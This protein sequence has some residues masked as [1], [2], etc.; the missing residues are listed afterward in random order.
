MEYYLLKS[1]RPYQIPEKNQ[2]L[3]CSDYL[4]LKEEGN[5]S[6]SEY[7]GKRRN[8]E[9]DGETST[10]LLINYKQKIKSIN[11]GAEQMAQWL[12][13]LFRGAVFGFQ[14]AWGCLQTSVTSVLGY[15]LQLMNSTNTRNTCCAHTYIHRGKY[16]NQ[17]NA[18]LIIQGCSFEIDPSPLGCDLVYIHFPAE[19]QFS[20]TKNGRRVVHF[21][22]SSFL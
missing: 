3:S 7:T 1:L 10:F 20:K 21:Y 13:Q 14:N 16:M 5:K 9:V 18:P 19:E 15:L 11:Y 6:D 8:E 17:K 22:F 12:E 4:K 2:S